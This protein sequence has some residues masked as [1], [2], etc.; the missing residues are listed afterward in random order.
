MQDK[1]TWKLSEEEKQEAARLYD[2]GLSLRQVAARYGINHG[3]MRTIL[4]M[5]TA[6]RPPSIVSNKCK[7]GHELAGA[8]LYVDP[9]GTRHC[10][11]CRRATAREI[12]ARTPNRPHNPDRLRAYRARNP[13]KDAAH[14]RINEEVRQGRLIKPDACERCGANARLAG[15]HADYSRPLDVEW[16]CPRCH[17]A[18]HVRLRGGAEE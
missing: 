15:H 13:E 14:Y 11:V 16:L 8:N 2:S 3:A 12:A 9:K 5:R 6:L 4:R 18:E 10:R 1:R 7:R 17:A